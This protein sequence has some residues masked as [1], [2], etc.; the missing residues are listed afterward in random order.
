MIFKE[1]VSEKTL[2]KL[3]SKGWYRHG[4]YKTILL[5]AIELL[6]ALNRESFELE[7]IYKGMEN[8]I[9]IG[10]EFFIVQNEFDEFCK[11]YDE[12][13]VNGI[14]YL[15]NY[16]SEYN[17]DMDKAI[18]LS[19]EIGTMNFSEMTNSE[20]ADLFQKSFKILWPLHHWL[21][22]ME[23]LNE[24]FDKKI[25][26]LMVQRYPKWQDGE[27]DAFLGK[28]SYTFKR[29]F[30]QSE[31][32]EIMKLKS[33]DVNDADF[34]KVFEKYRWLKMYFIDAAPFSVEEYRKRVG[35]MFTNRNA[36]EA[37]ISRGR[38]DAEQ[39]KKLV[40]SV[41]DTELEAYLYFMQD[42]SHL[43][44]YRIDVYTLALYHTIE[45]RNEI[46]KRLGITFQQFIDHTTVE[47][48]DA[49]SGRPVSTSELEARKVWSAIKVD[50][51]CEEFKGEAAIK[52]IRNAIWDET[53]R[54]ESFKGTVAF[55]GKVRGR[56]CVSFTSND[57]DRIEQGD[58]LVCNLT[59]PDYNHVFP[60]LAGIV[61]DEGGVL[62][63]S[64]IMA[65]EFK[66]P[67]IIGTKIA[68][69]VL[70]T[71]DVVEVDAEKGIVK[72]L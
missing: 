25:R 9:S 1:T 44:T 70:R 57:T 55:P 21:W 51:V 59:N 24:S 13:L 20:L 29:Q 8:S 38:E 19:R 17:K 16:I 58:I 41:E 39:A 7:G 36:I 72:V 53:E 45:L 6:P 66:I 33:T 50:G 18:E 34:Q 64:A 14:P 71:G 68:T 27:I 11:Q 31:Q 40:E 5:W 3:K 10:G 32:E 47:V 37:Q 35:D 54:R 26:G 22:S 42:L 62:C 12:K 69:K 60:K 28:A 46:I 43:K 48:V 15:T 56:V 30:F 23:F 63:H 52:T 67:C 49:L 61:T 4:I 65:R 2:A